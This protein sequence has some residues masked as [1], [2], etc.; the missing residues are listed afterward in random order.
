MNIYHVIA[1]LSPAI[2]LDCI[3]THAIVGDAFFTSKR[4]ASLLALLWLLPYIGYFIVA[5]ILVSE[6]VLDSRGKRDA[7]IG[8]DLLNIGIAMDD[9]NFSGSSDFDADSGH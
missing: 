5:R 3:T 6:G 8:G 2:L 1:I 9:G 7:D 4:K